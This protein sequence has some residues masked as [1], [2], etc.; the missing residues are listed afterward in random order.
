MDAQFVTGST[1]APIASVLAFVGAFAA[2][3]G[4]MIA[5]AAAQQRDAFAAACLT[6]ANMTP[7]ICA[8]QAKLARA[9][10]DRREQ[11][12]ALTALRGDRENFGKQ[13]RAMGQAKAK[14]FEGKMARLSA[15]SRAQ[16]R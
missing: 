9:N 10:L 16:C 14:T 13:V 4:G 1:R 7:A 5:P 15:Q 6:R 2:A 3:L 11:Q 8:C 12:A